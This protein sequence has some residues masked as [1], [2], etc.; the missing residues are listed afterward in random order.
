MS[1][2]NIN[3]RGRVLIPME[4]MDT[5]PG[6]NVPH[7]KI[8]KCGTNG[9]LLVFSSGKCRLMGC[10]KVMPDKDQFPIPVAL[11]AIQCITVR[12]DMNHTINLLHLSNSLGPNRCMFEP[13]LFCALRITQDFRPL[14]VNVFASGKVMIL[15][16]KTLNIKKI[17][18][19]VRKYINN[20]I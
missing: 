1:I 13:E 17:C 15:G 6:S 4:K 10:K 9:K 11:D 12:M 8:L 20:Y 16:I 14:C 3:F 2:V 19:R 18:K 7:I 5:I